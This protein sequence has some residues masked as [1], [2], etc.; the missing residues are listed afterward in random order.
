[1]NSAATESLPVPSRKRGRQKPKIAN[2][3][4]SDY[5]AFS[6]LHADVEM[7]GKNYLFIVNP[8]LF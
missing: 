4:A 5:T 1:M 3:N 2:W 7:S 6:E 8:F